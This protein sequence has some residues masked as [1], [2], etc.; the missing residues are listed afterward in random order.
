[1]KKTYIKPSIHVEQME[2][3]TFILAGSNAYTN[4]HCLCHG[5]NV[6]CEGRCTCTHTCHNTN[7]DCGGFG[8]VFHDDTYDDPYDPYFYE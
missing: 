5:Q 2:E 3:S 8:A 1:M 7:H 6:G 4:P